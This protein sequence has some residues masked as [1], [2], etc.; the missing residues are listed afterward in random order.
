MLGPSGFP[1]GP[2]YFAQVFDGDDVFGPHHYRNDLVVLRYDYEQ[3]ETG[4]PTLSVEVPNPRRG[5]IAAGV[6]TWCWFSVYNYSSAA[7]TGPDGN[8]Y[9]SGEVVPLFHGRLMSIPTSILNETITLQYQTWP[10]DFV[11]QKQ[12]VA[13]TIKVPPGY[14]PIW[15]DDEHRDDPDSILQGYSRV[16]NINPVTMVVSTTDVIIGED[17]IITF[18][19]GDAPYDSVEEV[20]SQTP[21]LQ[22]V[23]IEATVGWKQT[24]TGVVNF[25]TNT[26]V[27]LTGDSLI[28]SWPHA[29]ASLGGGWQIDSATARDVSGTAYI[30]SGSANYSYN[31]PAKFHSFGDMMSRTTSITWPAGGAIAQTVV[32]NLFEQIGLQAP[33]GVFVTIEG[34]PITV[35]IPFVYDEQLFFVYAWIIG[36]SLALRYLPD[37]DYKEQLNITLQAS[38]QAV[39]VDPTIQQESELIKLPGVDVGQPLINVLSW[40]AVAGKV[41]GVG[42]VVVPTS[43]APAGPNGVISQ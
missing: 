32:L 24:S 12:Q 6:P 27:S 3:D 11:Q 36:T 7:V 30:V 22:N 21:P 29:G 31:N 10:D 20:I 14:D 17:G 23:K 34:A 42:T 38:T 43:Q 18:G 37:R 25:G 2:F 15:L 5:L 33:Q 19:Q 13:E 9:A 1:P 40:L 4:K 41:V 35:N 16:W 39:V 28:S 8:S 26:F